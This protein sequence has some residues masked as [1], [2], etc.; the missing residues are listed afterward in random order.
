MGIRGE[1]FT[2]KR[3]NRDQNNPRRD[4]TTL[5]K[6]ELE[7]RMDQAIENEYKNYLR[8]MYQRYPSRKAYLDNAPFDDFSNERLEELWPEE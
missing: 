8:E 1:D 5:G 7:A 2:Y 6:L 4:L 3:Y